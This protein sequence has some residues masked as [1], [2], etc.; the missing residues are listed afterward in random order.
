[1]TDLGTL[2][3]DTF[4]RANAI[5]S[6]GQIVGESCYGDCSRHQRNERAVLWQDGSIVDLNTRIRGHSR[7][8]LTIAFAIDERGEIAGI[9]NPP[10]CR[11]DTYCNHAFL[12][13]P[14]DEN[15]PGV[16]GCDYGLVDASTASP[17]PLV[18]RKASGK[19][20]PATLQLRSNRFHLPAVNPW[21]PSAEGHK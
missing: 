12:L 13:I 5:N 17:P 7:L 16:E 20:L 11:F 9:G 2:E 8:K 1:M 21:N 14:C 18:E 4:S 19:T 6:E 15:H 10:G 3:D